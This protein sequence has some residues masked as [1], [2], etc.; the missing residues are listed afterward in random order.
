MRTLFGDHF[1]LNNHVERI[2]EM[3][4]GAEELERLRIANCENFGDGL[5]L[6]IYGVDG[7]DL[8]AVVAIEP[9]GDLI[10]LSA[11]YTDPSILSEEFAVSDARVWEVFRGVYVR[12]RGD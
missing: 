11:Q 5:L 6:R 3:L 2:L 1:Q 4:G 9:D 7:L 8:R 10:I 12:A